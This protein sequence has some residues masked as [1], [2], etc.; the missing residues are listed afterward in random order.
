MS[1]VPELEMWFKK[2][3]LPETPLELFPGTVI[4]D[5][6][7]F[8]NSHFI[9]LRNDPSGAKNEAHLYRLRSLKA[10]IDKKNKD[11]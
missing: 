5:M 1:L 9:P 11:I 10:I 6:E 3:D 2:A 4:T 7:L 8:L